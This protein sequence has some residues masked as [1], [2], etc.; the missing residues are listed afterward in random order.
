MLLVSFPG[1]GG[2]PLLAFYILPGV[3]WV[4]S[5]QVVMPLVCSFACDVL[6]Q[7]L[8]ICVF[9]L[10]GMKWVWSTHAENHSALSSKGR[11]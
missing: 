3:A 7:N 9:V 6:C 11:V 4:W 1:M 5:T 2:V 8:L 10:A